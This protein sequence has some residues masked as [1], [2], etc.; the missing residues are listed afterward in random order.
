MLD[1]NLDLGRHCNTPWS[2]VVVTMARPWK[3]RLIGGTFWV[4]G[5]DGKVVKDEIFTR[6]FKQI[7]NKN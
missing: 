6:T 1:V 4:N 5:D 3:E 2:A 7:N